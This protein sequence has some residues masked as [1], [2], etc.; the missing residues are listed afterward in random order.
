MHIRM[1][2]KSQLEVHLHTGCSVHFHPGRCARPSFS[3]FRGSGS[4]TTEV[5]GPPAIYF[6]PRAIFS[7]VPPGIR[8]NGSSL[9]M[10]PP[11]PFEVDFD[12]GVPFGSNSVYTSTPADVPD[13]PFRFFEG[14][15]PRLLLQGPS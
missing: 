14:L 1:L 12:V 2:I 4:E 9:E 15:V 13:P 10:V 6:G 3:I 8:V 11:Q 5:G 7:A